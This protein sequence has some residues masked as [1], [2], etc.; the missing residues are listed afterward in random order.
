MS[1]RTTRE[2]AIG[3]LFGIVGVV[4][5]SLTTGFVNFYS[6]EKQQQA[7]AILDSFK[8]D[9]NAP[10]EVL[11]LKQFIDRTRFLS[12]VNGDTVAHMAQIQRKHPNCYNFSG[13]DCLAASVEGIQATRAALGVGPAR[14]EDVEILL[15]DY[16]GNL[17][18]AIKELK[19]SE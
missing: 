18:H 5:G 1:E 17:Q 13:K 15:H 8:F 11:Q 14:D 2:L 6:Q 3:A 16:Y 9:T 10:V 19:D 12:T 7:Q 4:V